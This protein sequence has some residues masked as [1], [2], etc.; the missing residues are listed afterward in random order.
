M[1]WRESYKSNRPDG[2]RPKKKRFGI[3][4]LDCGR[5]GKALSAAPEAD[6]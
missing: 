6:N 5:S 1:E 3:T 4:G 2:K